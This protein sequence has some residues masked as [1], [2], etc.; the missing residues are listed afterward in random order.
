MAIAYDQPTA[1]PTPKMTAVGIAGSVTVILLYLVKVIFNVDMPA[2]VAS[3]IT[4][5]ISFGAGYLKRDE[6]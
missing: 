3:A 5:V 4:A 1:E 2:E 6:R